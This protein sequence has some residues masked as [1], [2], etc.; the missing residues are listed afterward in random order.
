MRKKLEEQVAA[1]L[2]GVPALLPYLPELL[3]DLWEIGGS[4]EIVAELLRPLNLPPRSTWLLDLGCGKGAIAIHLAKE[5]SFRV[6]GV[7]GFAPFIEEA[8]KH[9]AE[10]GVADLCHFQYG[11]LR[12]FLNPKHL[13]D[14]VVYAGVG[15]FDN[16]GESVTNLRKCVRRGCYIIIDDVFLAEDAA[17]I[18]GYAGYANHDETIRRL[19]AHGDTLI[20]EVIIPSEELREENLKNTKLIRRRA[21]R[22]AQKY[23]ADAGLILSYVQK[24]ESETDLLGSAIPCAVWLL[25][26]A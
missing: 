23:P 11:D 6:S 26:R 5:F 19:T 18:P 17:N 21:Q 13:F 2:D 10:N 9:A 20:K 3:A 14:V 12:D 24:Q 1:S 15:A 8:K 4:R 22:L 7:D 16:L 25:Q